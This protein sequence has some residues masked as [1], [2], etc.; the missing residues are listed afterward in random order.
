MFS[1]AIMMIR[2]LWTGESSSRRDQ[3]TTAAS[4]K[5][6]QMCVSLR[7]K[8][9]ETWCVYPSPARGDRCAALGQNV[10]QN[11]LGPDIQR[12]LSATNMSYLW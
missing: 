9:R 3:S 2:I 11:E 5:T 8:L 12:I 1:V 10:V 4:E 7:S 6:H